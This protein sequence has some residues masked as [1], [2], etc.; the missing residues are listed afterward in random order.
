MDNAMSD[1]P[2]IMPTIYRLDLKKIQYLLGDEEK[3]TANNAHEYIIQYQQTLK[4]KGETKAKAFEKKLG[5]KNIREYSVVVYGTNSN[6]EKPHPWKNLFAE[7]LTGIETKYP[8]LAA[9]FSTGEE[10][11]AISA[12]QGQ[13]LFD[14]FVDTNFPLEAAKHIMKPELTATDRR[15]IAGA[16]Y[17]QLQQYRTA[18][19]IV[20]SQNLGTVWR[21]LK[22]K[23]SEE[24]KARQDFGE[25][26]ETDK[27]EI[28]ITA[29]S[30]LSIGRS[31]EV[32]D[33][34][35]LLD[36][37]VKILDEPLT[38]KQ[39]EDFDFLNGLTEVSPRKGKS[40]IEQLKSSL[41]KTLFDVIATDKDIDFDFSH[42]RFEAYQEAKEYSFMV[43]SLVDVW[44]IP[45]SA[46]EVIY[47]M[48]NAGMFDK[49]ADGNDLIEIIDK[50]FFH[51]E[52]PDSIQS[53]SGSVLAH[54]H[55]EVELGSKRYFLIDGTWYEASDDFIGR[56]EKDFKKLI[57]GQFFTP[58][59]KLVLDPYTSTFKDEG[60]YNESYI[61]KD[62]WLV[63]D[64]VFVGYAEISDLIHW[65]D[66]NVYIIHNKHEFGVT[67][68]DVSS[69]ILHSMSIINRVKNGGDIELLGT[70]YDRIVKKYYQ[71]DSPPISREDFINKLL[72]TDASNFIYVIGY[73]REKAVDDLIGSNIAK[74]ESVK[75][76]NT[77]IKPFGFMFKILHITKS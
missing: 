64:R 76:C 75:L 1:I 30:S 33:L 35:T 36:W 60:A 73:I 10:C 53:V 57:N 22:G 17:G 56:V 37:L 28:S 15:E 13:N 43:K 40:T 70:Y 47:S 9:F 5:P 11:Y 7:E 68:R 59:E 50:I 51:A 38:Q 39:I 26:F 67:V 65:D 54:L 71:H 20:S 31:V 66:D 49:C 55:G 8:N 42:K 25:I 21:T 32:K 52:H 44:N 69:Q 3:I 24:V 61:G 18:Q 23:V 77:D 2:K 58:D 16:I 63:G 34:I 46:S 14:I 74:F 45:P 27:K 48:K 72:L 62:N 19:T 41:G 12:G 29:G 4:E 6:I